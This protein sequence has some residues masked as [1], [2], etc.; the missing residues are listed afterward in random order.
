VT[1]LKNP[2]FEAAQ[3]SHLIFHARKVPEEIPDRSGL[4]AKA[5]KPVMELIA[6]FAKGPNLL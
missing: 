4:F 1:Q 5:R 2:R 3:L 6:S